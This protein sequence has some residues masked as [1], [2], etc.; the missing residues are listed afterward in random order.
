MLNY[1]KTTQLISFCFSRKDAL[2]IFRQLPKHSV[3]NFVALKWQSRKKNV[4]YHGTPLC[5]LVLIEW[6][7][8]ICWSP[9]F[10][11]VIHSNQSAPLLSYTKLGKSEQTV[12]IY[13]QRPTLYHLRSVHHCLHQKPAIKSHNKNK[14]G[15]LTFI[16]LIKKQSASVRF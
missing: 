8:A 10:Q 1:A 14:T 2:P 13:R 15:C 4:G 7:W 6:N 5:S 3:T 9:L 11:I 12:L 16:C